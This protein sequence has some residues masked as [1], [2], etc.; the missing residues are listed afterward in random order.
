[1][2]KVTK[3][4][5]AGAGILILSGAGTSVAQT[6]PTTT[7][8][9]VLVAFISA[10]L[11]DPNGKVPVLNG[12][13]GAGVANL[14]VALPQTV[15]VHGNVYDYVVAFQNGAYTG[16]CG[17]SFLL[18]QGTGASKKILDSGVIKSSYSCAAGTSWAWVRVGKVIPDSPGLAS[19]TAIVTY[20]T[21]HAYSKTTVL[22]Q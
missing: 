14:S 1:M 20:G 7:T 17:V 22:I 11:R 16:N 12:V 2:D 18:T 6:A 8:P 13:P 3:L 4:L 19:L 15:L 9:G 5:A 21:S 10:G